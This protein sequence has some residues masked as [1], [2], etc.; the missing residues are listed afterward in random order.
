MGRGV[1]KMYDEPEPPNA[2]GRG[3]LKISDET[4]TPRCGGIA[5]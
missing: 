5:K 3:L 2:N 4:E 1:F